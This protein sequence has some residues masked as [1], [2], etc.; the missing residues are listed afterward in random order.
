MSE[1]FAAAR[2][3][4]AAPF[5][6]R[7][8][9]RNGAAFA[10]LLAPGLAGGGITGG[11]AATAADGAVAD[12]DAAAWA[13]GY[14]AGYA[15]AQD[16][17]SAAQLRVADA[18]TALAAAL[19]RLA[20]APDAVVE[21]ALRRQMLS[22]LDSL[23]GAAPVDAVRLNGAVT[24][25]AVEAAAA[26]DGWRL[27]VAPADMALIDDADALPL[28]ANPTLAPGNI[29][30]EQGARQVN[31]GPAVARAALAQAWGIDDRDAPRQ[32]HEP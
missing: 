8:G 15:A 5:H 19:D 27:H 14:A 3:I 26:T 31:A 4:S 20:P 6:P 2:S 24:A 21:A 25:L 28:I 12:G 7:W 10:P 22:A 16:D 11:D 9:S 18:Q 13:A 30:L 17:E 23:I 1:V 32:G 29:R